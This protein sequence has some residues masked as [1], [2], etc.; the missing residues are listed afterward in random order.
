MS[1]PNFGTHYPLLAAALA[2]V[3]EGPVLELGCGHFSTPMLH[4]MCAAQKRRL[5]TFETD[6]E[7]LDEFLTY[8]SPLHSFQH[9]PLDEWPEV[10]QIDAIEWGV[11]FVDHKPGEMRVREI[12][13]LQG[14]TKLLVCHDTEPQPWEMDRRG[15][16]LNPWKYR[17]D[18]DAY[19]AWATAV[20]DEI[21]LKTVFDA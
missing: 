12:L 1:I 4:L 5:Y 16:G 13:R 10:N 8:E 21:D 19:Q 6:Q 14:H 2:L 15:P 20:S 7:W 11:A 3:P 9:V 17:Y 18:F